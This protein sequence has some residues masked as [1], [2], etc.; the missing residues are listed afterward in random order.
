MLALQQQG[1]HLPLRCP[2][3]PARDLVQQHDARA[4]QRRHPQ[5]EQLLLARREV[6]RTEVRGEPT[7]RRDH[8]VPQA[9]AGKEVGVDEAREGDWGMRKAG[10]AS[11]DGGQRDRPIAITSFRALTANTASLPR[12]T[13]LAPAHPYDSPDRQRASRDAL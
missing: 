3:Q 7:P 4:A 9:G 8:A 5:R 6:Q 10:E 12:A 11:A 2:A 13:G 1:A